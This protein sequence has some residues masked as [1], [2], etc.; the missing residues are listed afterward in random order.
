MT[1]LV[2]PASPAL[3]DKLEYDDAAPAEESA[4]AEVAPEATP[5]APEVKRRRDDLVCIAVVADDDDDDVSG[6][7]TKEEDVVFDTV[8][9]IF[10]VEVIFTLFVCT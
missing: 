8:A 7:A 1:V 9:V 5:A 4:N 6:D 3:Y 10:G 2:L